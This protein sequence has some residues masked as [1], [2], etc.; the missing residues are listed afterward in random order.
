VDQSEDERRGLGA[1]VVGPAD[2]RARLRNGLATL[3]E[4]HVISS[5]YKNLIVV[6]GSKYGTSS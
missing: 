5:G 2:L 6:S 3:K 1:A 4:P